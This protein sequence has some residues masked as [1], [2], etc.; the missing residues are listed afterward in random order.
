MIEWPI[1]QMMDLTIRVMIDQTIH[2]HLIVAWWSGIDE[3]LTF[4][5]GFVMKKTIRDGILTLTILCG[6]GPEYPPCPPF[7]WLPCPPWLRC[8]RILTNC[9]CCWYPPWPPCCCKICRYNK[10]LSLSVMDG[11]DDGKCWWVI[12]FDCELFVYLH[13]FNW[14]WSWISAMSVSVSMSLVLFYNHFD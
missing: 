2:R 14:S 9:G 6:P 11:S 10:I 1:H 7:P 12:W 4:L 8:T 3:K 5:L 13:N